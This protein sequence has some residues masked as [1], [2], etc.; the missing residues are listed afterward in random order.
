[1]ADGFT[2]ADG[3]LF[4][5]VNAA[6]LIGS[7]ELTGELTGESDGFSLLPTANGFVL[8]FG[9]LPAGDYDRNGV[10]DAAEYEVWRAEFGSAAS[11]AADG[12][13]DGTVDAADYVVWRQHHGA[14]VFASDTNSVLGVAHSSVPEPPMALSVGCA[15]LVLV[16]LMRRGMA[17]RHE[18]RDLDAGPRTTELRPL[19]WQRLPAN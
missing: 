3:D 4:R 15:L 6:E 12:N 10:V 2:P 8:Y 11:P 1:M 16:V 7:L 14:S 9:A 13:G 19:S 17:D 5:I 18:H